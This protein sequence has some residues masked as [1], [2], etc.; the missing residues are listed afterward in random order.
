[1]VILGIVAVAKHHG[2]ST[3]GLMPDRMAIHAAPGLLT[4]SQHDAQCLELTWREL[5]GTEKESPRGSVMAM[6]Q[7]HNGGEHGLTVDRVATHTAPGLLTQ[8][9]HYAQ[10]LELTWRA[11]VALREKEKKPQGWGMAG[12]NLEKKTRCVN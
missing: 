4:Q 6:A 12:D 5:H 3:H 1:V 9:Q 7:C 11:C 2:G 10:C 8:S